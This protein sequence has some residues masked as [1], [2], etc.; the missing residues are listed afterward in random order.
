M[1]APFTGGASLAALAP[2]MG[3]AIGKATSASGNNRLN[4]EQLGISANRD[5]IAGN[6]AAEN[7]L[8][9]RSELEGKERHNALIDVARASDTRN[10]NISQFNT[11]A[12]KVNS[13]EYMST[14]TA[15]EQ[16]G[17]ARLKADPTYSTDHMTPLRTYKP[18]DIANLQGA[19]GTKPG[20]FERI[21][22]FAGPALSV[23][24]AM[25][26]GGASVPSGNT[27]QRLGLNIGPFADDESDS[28]L[29]DN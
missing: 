4:Q 16:A 1:A 2:L 19:T 3:D 11:H 13:P 12:P 28:I 22:Q 29:T 14:L 5:N 8:M 10:P 17:M 23:Y 6:A 18:L 7:A 15:L 20:L 27:G 24:G 21:G 25:N 9:N 26:R